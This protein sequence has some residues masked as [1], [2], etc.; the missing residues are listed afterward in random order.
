MASVD[1]AR[2]RLDGGTQPRAT[3]HADW[4]E[5]YAA[6][7]GAGA[8]FPPVTVF[9]DGTDYWLA[10]G[11]HRTHAATALGLVEI[12]ADIRQ[13]TQRDAILFSVG[14]NASHGQRRTNEDK[15]RAVLRLLG[16]AEWST[17]PFREIARDCAVAE[18]FVRKLVPQPSAHN[19]QMERPLSRTV[20]R[21]GTTYQMN[22][23][24][25]GG[26]RPA[27]APPATL[28]LVPPVAR[29]VPPTGPVSLPEC[30]PVWTPPQ[31]AAVVPPK[32]D[33]EA[34]A[35]REKAFA[36][37]RALS[38]QPDP[39]AVIDAWMKHRGYGEPVQTIEKAIAWLQAFLPLYREAEPKR[40]A[41][42]EE[43]LDRVA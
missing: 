43:R 11:F 5:E 7:M 39:Q 20:T 30:E 21:G 27:A 13:G 32:F 26:H 40:W 24:A 35:V 23:A 14:A 2:I 12:D 25:I 36:A 1:I 37:I 8:S 34:A 17:K 16:D 22:T 18:S 3:I 42:I 9:F 41:A 33:H 15:R 38:E 10:D 29:E 4:I 6:D 28:P 19:A 31:P